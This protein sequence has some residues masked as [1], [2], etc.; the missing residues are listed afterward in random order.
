LN[1]RMFYPPIPG[2]AG[3]RQRLFDVL[4]AQCSQQ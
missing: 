2:A 1:R 3:P 4:A